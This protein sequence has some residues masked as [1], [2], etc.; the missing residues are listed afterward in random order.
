M[1]GSLQE[2][3]SVLTSLNIM[4]RWDINLFSRPLHPSIL[5][6]PQNKNYSECQ[7]DL[8]DV[9]MPSPDLSNWVW[10]LW[11]FLAGSMKAF[12]GDTLTI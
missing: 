7:A 4:F 12:R 10:P 11:N 5:P 3:I 6:L 9:Q 2:I 8:P 1:D